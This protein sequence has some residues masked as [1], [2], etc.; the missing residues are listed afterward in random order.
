MECECGPDLSELSSSVSPRWSAPLSAE[1]DI[2]ILSDVPHPHYCHTSTGVNTVPI[3]TTVNTGATVNTVPTF[4]NFTSKP[5]SMEHNNININISLPQM[6][7]VSTT[8]NTG[9]TVTPTLH[10][11]QTCLGCLS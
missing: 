11:S 6:S 8:V 1:D 5:L 10:F 4:N 2:N 9:G 7:P 3:D